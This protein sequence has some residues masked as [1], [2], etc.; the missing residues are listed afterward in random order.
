M[1]I[2]EGL[3]AAWGTISR[4]IAAFAAFMAFLLAVKSGGAG[5]LFA[6]VLASAAVVVL[7]FVANWLLKKLAS[8]ARKVGAKLKGLAEKFK[9]KRKAKKDAKAGK[10]HDEHDGASSKKH[11]DDE[12]DGASPKKH[13]DDEHDAAGPKTHKDHDEHEGSNG[14]KTKKDDEHDKNKKERQK[15]ED[16]DKK[17]Q[18]ILDK[19]SR[20]LP[21]KVQAALK[22]QP[23]KLMF[24]ARLA[25]WR[26]QYRLTSLQMVQHGD[27]F[28]IKATVNPSIV[29]PGGVELE[30][31]KMLRRVGDRVLR[32]NPAALERAA[33]RAGELGID[34][35]PSKSHR[36][37]APKTAE[38]RLAI[39]ADQKQQQP[40]RDHYDRTLVHHGTVEGGGDVQSA[41]IKPGP[42]GERV[43]GD[44]LVVSTNLDGGPSTAKRYK[45][46]AETLEGRGITPKELGRAMRIMSRGFSAPS[47]M[48]GSEKELGELMGLSFGTEASRDSRNPLF[49]MMAIEQM[50]ASPSGTTISDTFAKLP[51]EMKG[52]VRAAEGLNTALDGEAPDKRHSQPKVDTL[53]KR[54]L[55]QLQAW[56]E[57]KTG[58]RDLLSTSIEE[59]ET[60]VEDMVRRFVST[61]LR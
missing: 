40:D 4:I 43:Q 52:H 60:F 16:K 42:R 21:P 45:A 13:H 51:A 28:T 56:F 61:Y 6:T 10:H 34:P 46:L 5:P 53:I 20:E 33:Q 38:E 25:L 32:E 27:R 41:H 12:H 39:A 31:L 26:V 15:K 14:K 44:E 36:A 48:K 57:L 2:I 55:D 11:H 24:R 19:A 30:I 17:N 50:E 47:F 35:T 18:E 3:Q 1:T 22:K 23:G 58:G 8:A 9:S 7:D 49:S 54:Q 37:Y 59:V 29:L